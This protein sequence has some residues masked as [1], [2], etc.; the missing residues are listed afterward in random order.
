MENGIEITSTEEHPFYVDGLKLA[1][2][3]PKNSKEIHGL[4]T[5]TQQIK[6][7][8]TLYTLNGGKSKITNIDEISTESTNVYII[9]VQ[10]NHNFFANKILVHN[11]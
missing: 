10:D 11:K 7:G 1:S 9:T 8:D 5:E 6:V 4:K 3:N 2:F